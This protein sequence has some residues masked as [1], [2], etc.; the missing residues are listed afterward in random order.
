M[1]RYQ[2]FDSGQRGWFSKF[3]AIHFK[4]GFIFTMS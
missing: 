3:R 4:E 2:E 1:Q